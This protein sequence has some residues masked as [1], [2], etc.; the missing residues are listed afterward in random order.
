M[1]NPHEVV[2]F[3]LGRKAS[4]GV[5]ISTDVDKQ[6]ARKV[7][8]RMAHR[9]GGYVPTKWLKYINTNYDINSDA[10]KL[11]P[12]MT[13]PVTIGGVETT[14]YIESLRRLNFRGLPWY[15]QMRVNLDTENMPVFIGNESRCACRY[16]GTNPKGNETSCLSCGAPLPHC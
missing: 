10:I 14:M 6:Q 1:I 2:N 11:Q 9:Y 4:L 15:V 8:S 5:K 7:L 13:V 3:L 12:G 16:C